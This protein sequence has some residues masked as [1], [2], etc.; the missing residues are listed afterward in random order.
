MRKKVNVIIVEPSMRNVLAKVHCS[1][2]SAVYNALAY[3]SMSDKAEAI[4]RDALTN[5]GG[6]LVSKYIWTK[7]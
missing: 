6:K 7:Y 1:C 3:R 5:Y 4:R 2:M